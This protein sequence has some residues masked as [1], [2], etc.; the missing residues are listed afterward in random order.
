MRPKI[1]PMFTIS[2]RAIP[3]PRD[4]GRLHPV[5]AERKPRHVNQ[6]LAQ[7]RSNAGSAFAL[8]SRVLPEIGRFGTMPLLAELWWLQ[9][10]RSAFRVSC[11][12]LTDLTVQAKVRRS[13]RLCSGGAAEPCTSNKLRRKFAPF[14]RRA[15]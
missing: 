13:S 10:E 14:R 9:I 3:A 1:A 6:G 7:N 5:R 12:R 15:V 11:A 8:R 2:R 4:C